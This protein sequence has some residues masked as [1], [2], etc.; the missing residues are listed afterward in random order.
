MR[1]GLSL[2]DLHTKNMTAYKTFMAA[3]CWRMQVSVKSATSIHR[4]KESTVI[5]G[6]VTLFFL[7]YHW[8]SIIK[9]IKRNHNIQ[10]RT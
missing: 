7:A 9:G 3:V 2:E 4:F 10:L 1:A 5:E 6:L 8:V